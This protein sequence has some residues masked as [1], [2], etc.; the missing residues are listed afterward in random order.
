M[1][2]AA[3]SLRL[4][5]LYVNIVRLRGK[6]MKLSVEDNARVIEW[7]PVK[8]SNFRCLHRC[9]ASAPDVVYVRTCDVRVRHETVVSSSPYDDAGRGRYD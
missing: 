9:E 2:I 5:L 8:V 1:V 6:C 7:S 4:A 3:F